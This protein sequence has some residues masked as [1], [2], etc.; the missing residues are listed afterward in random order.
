MT[1]YLTAVVV[2]LNYFNSVL[3]KVLT[4][5]PVTLILYV[6]LVVIALAF[7]ALNLRVGPAV[8][9]RSQSVPEVAGGFSFARIGTL[10]LSL[11]VIWFA[12]FFFTIYRLAVVLK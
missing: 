4:T 1:Y 5:D 11:A 10:K 7:V 12:L 2:Y 8:H 9:G 6:C 3:S